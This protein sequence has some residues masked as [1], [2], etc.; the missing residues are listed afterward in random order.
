MTAD[1]L[2]GVSGRSEAGPLLAPVGLGAVAPYQERDD[3]GTQH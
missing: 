2:G 1:G 3:D